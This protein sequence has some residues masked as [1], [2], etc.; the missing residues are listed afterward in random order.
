MDC[1]YK[2]G[3]VIDVSSVEEMSRLK[4]PN[5]IIEQGVIL[6]LGIIE[7]QPTDI[8]LDKKPEVLENNFPKEE[9][10]FLTPLIFYLIK[11]LLVVLL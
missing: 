9:N 4:D 6:R 1:H 7:E 10:C 11:C 8:L 5:C 3:D 2:S